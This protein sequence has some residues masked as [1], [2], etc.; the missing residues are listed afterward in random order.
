MSLLFLGNAWPR[1]NKKMLRLC[2]SSGL[3]A[4][5]VRADAP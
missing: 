1:S 4:Q 3:M 5:T 2:W